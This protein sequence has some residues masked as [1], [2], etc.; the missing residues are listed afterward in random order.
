MR[1][2]RRP[3]SSSASTPTPRSRPADERRGSLLPQ[4]RS[5]RRRSRA[6]GRSAER[7]VL[8]ALGGGT[9]R[10]RSH[11]V[12]NGAGPLS[13]AV[14]GA[15]GE[16]VEQALRARVADVAARRCSR[17]R[18]ACSSAPTCRRCSSR[19]ATCR[20]PS[21][22]RRWP[23]AASRIRSR[24]RSSTPSS[25][26]RAHVERT[27]LRA[28]CRTAA[29]AAMN[30]TIAT[31]RRLVAH[32][33]RRRRARLGADGGL[34]ARACATAP[35]SA[36]ATPKRR[37]RRPT[38]SADARHA[39][40][41]GDALLR[42][43]GR[44]QPCR[45]R[46]GNPARRRQGRAG[47]RAR[48]GAARR[49]R[50]PNRWPRR[51]RR[52]RRCAASYVSDRNEAFVDLDAAVRD[53][54]PGGSM[55]ELFTVFTIVNAITT[56]LP[57]IQSVQILIDGREVDTLAGHVD[58]RRPL[59]KNEHADSDADRLHE[60]ARPRPARPAPDRPSRPTSSRTPKAPC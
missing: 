43:R 27:G 5:R 48:R 4:P 23:P 16:L 18:S 28:T 52:A 32:R 57:D 24:S 50:R 39:A 44:P 33:R 58:L 1:T 53:K 3:T 7:T 25:Q 40:D 34:F 9:P 46:A 13:R 30:R 17:R 8:P 36:P 55:N 19:S 60:I 22:K 51:S 29:P 49:R 11:S 14:L 41:Q 12:G 38:P 56:N 31:H 15:R 6:A 59:R 20:I 2:A 42:L 35:A 45:R 47:A 10:D 26:F 21:R 37:R 54:H